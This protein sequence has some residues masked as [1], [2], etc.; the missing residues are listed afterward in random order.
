MI[1][2]SLIYW[3]TRLDA[4]RQAA[5]GL[6]VLSVFAVAAGLFAL[7]V[8]TADDVPDPFRS[9]WRNVTRVAA[10]VLAVSWAVLVLTPTK[11]EMAAIIVVP[12]IANSETVAEIGDGVKTLAVEWLEELRPNKKGGAE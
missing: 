4:V 2:P 8:C 11:Q 12:R 1:T 10:V 7:F 6:C 5:G 9:I 3:I